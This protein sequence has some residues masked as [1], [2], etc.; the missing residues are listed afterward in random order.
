M[1]CRHLDKHT[2][3]PDYSSVVF[4]QMTTPKNKDVALRSGPRR[5]SFLIRAAWCDSISY[6]GGGPGTSQ[7]QL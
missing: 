4:K 6:H 5:A 3:S 1:D 7:T 2:L